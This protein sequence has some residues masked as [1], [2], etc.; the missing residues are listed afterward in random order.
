MS[1]GADLAR[2][3]G[4]GAEAALARR[5][6][7]RERS[8][9][10]ARRAR[11]D[12]AEWRLLV[13]SVFFL[14][15]FTAL[16]GRMTFL[17]AADPAEPR[18]DPAST[19]VAAVDRA[20]IVDRNGRLLAVNLPTWAIYAHPEEAARAGVD[21]DEA[22][23]RVASVLP[24]L[25]EETVRARFAPGRKFVWIKR[26]AS[27]AERQAVHDLGVPGV[28]FG[29]RE[30]RLYPAGRIGAH[31]LG[32]VTTGE[33][34]VDHAELVGLAG[35]ERSLDDE[36]RDPGRAG[37]PMALSL[38]LVAQAALTEVM[39][40]AV[41]EFGAIAASAVLMDARNG[42]IIAMVSLPDF[43][44][45]DRPDTHDPTVAKTRPMMNRVA[46]GVYELGSTF[47]LFAAAQA[48]DS[49]IFAPDSMIDTTGPIR[50]GKYR[51][52]DFHRM[53]PEMSLRDVIVES[54][55][56]GTSRVALAIGGA[57]Q[58]AFL[59]RLGFLEPT[60]VEVAEA[61]LGQPLFP[62]RWTEL[63]TMT[64]SYGHGL[65]ATQLHLAAA[66]ASLLNGG[67]LVEPTLR[68]DAPRPTEAD[69]VISAKTSRSLREMM[70]AVV[71]EEKGTANFAEAPG[72]EV[73]GKTGTAD[74][75]SR[76][77]YDR[78]KTISTFAGAFPMS[79]P[80]YVLVVTLDE[81]S[82]FRYGRTW[83]TAGWTAA[84]TA[85]L[86]VK[87]IAP[88]L[89]MRPAPKSIDPASEALVDGVSY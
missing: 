38:D 66:Y 9:E 36:L 33:E 16:A 37:A 48:I 35:V 60:S 56:V 6:A 59:K 45:N 26:P 77:G 12:R 28:Y 51:I 44:P 4:D 22:A 53:P 72:Y 15:G 32:G 25:S 86:A 27:P 41:T 42:E 40:E 89:G 80:K 29:R 10:E 14:A 84:P 3:L 69:R 62:E 79:S 39:E 85:G 67:L 58:K 73:G 1:A 8:R 57:A 61:N 82:T 75:P 76:G 20:A 5:A 65:A 11:A 19:T 74:K 71:A 30:T 13:V 24:E 83:R 23:R 70:R 31:V 63:S 21:A 18:L 64:I 87:R 17:A 46:E 52:N 34:S 43:N 81:A 55:N 7:R 68:L 50:V 47:K 88:L 54:S 49:G 78:S 2:L